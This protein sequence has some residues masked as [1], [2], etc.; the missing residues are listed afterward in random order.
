MKLTEMILEHNKAEILLRN[1]PIKYVYDLAAFAIVLIPEIAEATNVIA[2]ANK[3]NIDNSKQ[4]PL[5]VKNQETLPSGF[6]SFKCE[7]CGETY[8]KNHKC[9]YTEGADTTDGN[10]S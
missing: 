1:V 5:A 4:Q 7:L 6:I 3:G 2:P 9:H 8:T 10:V